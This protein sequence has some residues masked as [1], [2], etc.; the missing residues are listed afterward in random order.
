MLTRVL[1]ISLGLFVRN[2]K[3]WSFSSLVSK[4]EQATYQDPRQSVRAPNV[5]LYNP[6]LP[7]VEGVGLVRSHQPASLHCHR[8]QQGWQLYF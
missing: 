4:I 1:M 8:P 3:K 2:S 5:D 6:L 7:V